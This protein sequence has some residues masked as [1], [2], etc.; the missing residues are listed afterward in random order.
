MK[1]FAKEFKDFIAS[2]N[3][4][5][6]AVGVILATFVGALISA[7][8]NGVVLNLVAAIVGKPNFD[9]VLRIKLR[10]ADEGIDAATG[11]P[12]EATYL[13]FGKVITAFVTLVIVGLVLFFLIKGYNKF[14]GPKEEEA[15][16]PTEV[17][18]LTEIRDSLRARS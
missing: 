17:D 3:M 6:L 2:G 16:G 8:T 1:N 13:E 5:E 15:A 12:F 7:F 11:L 14:R 9:S 10:D 18:L 4:V